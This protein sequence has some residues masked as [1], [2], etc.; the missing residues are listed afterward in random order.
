[1]H[2]TNLD[3]LATANHGIV[4]RSASGLSRSSW[5][6]AITAGQLEQVYPGVARLHGTAR[7]TEQRIAAAVFATGPSSI[8]SH[9][10]AAHLWGIPRPDDD[11]VDVIDDPVDVIVVG[12]RRRF[13]G[14]DEVVIHR[15]R[16][17]ERLTPQRRSGIVCTNAL[18]AVLDLGAVD[19][20][21]VSDAVGH[22][23]TSRLATLNALET[24]VIQHS[25]HGRTGIVALREAVA[26]WSIDAKPSDSMLEQTMHRLITRHRLPPVDFHPVICGHE[27]DFRV[28]GTP[29]ILECDGW[30][31]HGL[32]RSNFER[33]RRRDADLLTA[34]WIVLRFTYRAI[35]TRPKDIVDRIV[36][37]ID[38]WT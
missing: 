35:T 13:T 1:M 7:T 37:T 38:R 5:Y 25:E 3:H 28:T 32:Q 23:I 12:A 20:S 22:L 34:G 21:A 30:A 18:R 16:D 2:L 9:R 27:V 36:A 14:F 31:Y 6:R 8:A 29:V 19:R 4:S 10:S 15:P 24:V 26:E 33:D 11:P 17:L